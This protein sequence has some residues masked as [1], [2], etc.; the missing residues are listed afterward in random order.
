MTIE[1]LFE[2]LKD[3]LSQDL[4]GE[5]TFDGSIIKWQYDGLLNSYYDDDLEN[6]LT[7][8]YEDDISLINEII[9]NENFEVS[10]PEIHD[11]FIFFYIE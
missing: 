10:E 3:E 1:K 8:K 7:Q 9:I 6:F 4:V 2:I 11:T 5:F